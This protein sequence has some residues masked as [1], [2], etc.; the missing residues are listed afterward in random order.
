MNRNIPV[1]ILCGGMGTRLSEYTELRPKP[2]VEIGGKPILWHIMK[3][4]S[5]YGFNE[6]IL[7]L[8]YKGELIKRYFMDFYSLNQDFTVSI[9]DGKVQS[10]SQNHCE[11]WKVHLIDTGQT[12]LTG[13]RIKRLASMINKEY[14]LMTYGDGVSDVN[15]ESL[16][17]F[18]QDHKGLVTLTAVRPPARF[19]A[20]EFEGDQ[21]R[22]FKE[23]STLHE[24]WIN[25]GFFVIN[26]EAL[27]YIK[28]D[29]MW[30]HAPMETL[31]KEGELYAYKH[32]GFWQCM[33]T[34]RDLKYL[35]NVWQTGKAPWKTW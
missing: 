35:E 9:N 29:V 18:H 30:E 5:Q 34:A 26:S 25:G 32:E 19:G 16:L 17:A 7:A 2:L 24:G 8:G 3:H 33:D 11:P 14:F 13:G 22:H 21:I 4:Y 31:A 1:V 6:F 20:L 15:F 23:K 12:T 27:S 10:I 28:D